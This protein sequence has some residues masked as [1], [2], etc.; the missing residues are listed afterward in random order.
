MLPDP[1]TV[2][3][4]LGGEDGILN[5]LEANVGHRGGDVAEEFYSS[6]DLLVDGWSIVASC[7]LE[8]D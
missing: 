8:H 1:S 2:V 5:K 3:R 4:C 7:G 6:T